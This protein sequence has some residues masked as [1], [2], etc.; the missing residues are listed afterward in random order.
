MLLAFISSR[1]AQFIRSLLDL[2]INSA[3]PASLASAY[4]VVDV[5]LIGAA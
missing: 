1:K 3:K 4:F 2:K 5:L